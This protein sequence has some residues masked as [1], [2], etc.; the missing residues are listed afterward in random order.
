MMRRIVSVSVFA[1]AL[2]LMVPA[3]ALAC[4]GLIAPGHAEVL[5]KATTLA[6]WHDGFEHYVTGFQFAGSANKFGY[7][8][9]L[10]GVP[11]K[12]QKAGDWTLERLDQ[13]VNPVE[14]F[15][16]QA[17]A[18]AA[19]KDVDVLQRVKVEALNI[20][21]VRGGGRD[22]AAWAKENGFDLTPDTPR[23]M[24][25]YSSQ[26]AIFA[27]AKF[28]NKEAV[29]RGLVEGQGTVIHFTIPMKAP[30]IPLRILALGKGSTEVVN[31]DLYILTDD[32]PSLSVNGQLG[33]SGIT[34]RKSEPA[35]E[36][37]LGD[38]RSDRGMKWLPTKGMWFTA[39]T[40]QSPAKAL[41][42]DLS[43][44]GGGPPAAPK[45]SIPIARTP[46]WTWALIVSLGI[47]GVVGMWLL[48]RPAASTVR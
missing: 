39:L 1:L 19:S 27:L 16:L 26:G 34:L 36:Q 43:I 18:G 3:V 7:I 48:W 47:G 30:W 42:F 41:G 45:F 29:K 5:R 37:L 22:V 13:E 12:I 10:P 44:D 14:R 17:V 25:S 20:V 6:A 28:D 4:G 38:L 40:L 23:V 9:P 15:A 46:G 24:S 32:R 2:V 35:S 8:I 21:V 31:A 33:K 11:T